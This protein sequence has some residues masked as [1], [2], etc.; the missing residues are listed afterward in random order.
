MVFRIPQSPYEEQRGGTL[1]G[2]PEEP[3]KRTVNIS[4][5][6]IA[7]LRLSFS[8]SRKKKDE[9]MHKQYIGIIAFSLLSVITALSFH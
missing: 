1:K 6:L 5:H 8:L 9:F 4:F 2:M 7:A 3:E